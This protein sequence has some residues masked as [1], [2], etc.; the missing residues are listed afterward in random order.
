MLDFINRI[1]SVIAFSL[2]LACVTSARAPA[3]LAQVPAEPAG[4]VTAAPAVPASIV[5][6][7]PAIPAVTPSPGPSATATPPTG[8][9]LAAYRVTAN[10]IAFYSNRY[11]VT[12]DGNVAITLGDGTKI[13]GNTFFMDLRLNRF[14]IAGNVA[15]TAAGKTIHGA[16]FSEYFDFDRAYFVPIISE[17]D[18]WTFVSGDYAHPALGREMP[19][20]TFFLPDLTGER[21]FLLSKRATID[22]RQSVRF[23]PATL[24]FGLASVPFPAYFLDFSPNPNYAQNSLTGAYVDG[25]YDFAGGEH[26]LATAHIRYDSA[27]GLFPA[28]EQHYI[29]NNGYVVGS[30]SPLTRPLKVY[31]LLAYNRFSPGLSAQYI[32]QTIAFQHD[33]ERPLSATALSTLQVTG[34]LPHSFLQLQVGQ[35]YDSLLPRPKPGVNGLLYYGD[36]SHN[37]VPD[38]PLT[39][40]LSW[41]G[42][43]IPVYHRSLTYQL[44]SF[45]NYAHNG[46]TPLQQ[47]GG[48]NY[49]TLYGKGAG[50]NVVTKSVTIQHDRRNRDLY[51]TGVFD[52][53]RTYYSSP[54]HVDV[55]TE[56]ISL[57]KIID[58]QKLTLLLAYT[59]QN[60]GDFYGA[61][62]PL[63]YASQPAYN[64]FTGQ[65]NLGYSSF[66]GFATTRSFNEQLVWTPNQI[67]NL[68]TTLRENRDYP[69][70][71]AGPPQIV[72]PNIAFANYGVSPYQATL[73]VRYRFTRQLVIDV[74][75]SYYFGFGGYER[76]QPQFSIQVEK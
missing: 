32:F 54:H 65:A 73:E 22:P 24:N 42:F 44:R 60:V 6:A 41:V 26:G 35:I 76:W 2:V 43:R 4:P 48:V 33:F 37:W 9:R 34:S 75:R 62:Q 64:P 7:P 25:P 3:A 61:Q 50:I 68:V 16:A 58:P 10:R 12:A 47:L 36:P 39:G 70:A 15:V 63:A 69:D 46:D 21:V 59:N 55:Q 11:I 38:H 29:T 67:F 23:A 52:K 27:N 13:G 19:G 72:G 1:I 51:F 53:Q 74:Q 66:R 20:D 56:T 30:I 5:T 28:F 45:V 49:R 14:V 71:I 40:T 8:R 18:R 31:N 57:T 17:P